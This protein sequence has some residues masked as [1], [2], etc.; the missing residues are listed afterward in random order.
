MPVKKPIDY[1]DGID[2]MTQVMS[3]DAQEALKRHGKLHFGQ[4]PKDYNQSE[5]N[6][7]PWLIQIEGSNIIHIQGEKNKQGGWEG[8]VIRLFEKYGLCIGYMCDGKL[9]G[10]GTTIDFR[11]KT[12]IGDIVRDRYHGTGTL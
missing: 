7:I 12:Y 3:K 10:P 9:T 4:P 6:F 1:F 5:K 11:G 8:R 2:E